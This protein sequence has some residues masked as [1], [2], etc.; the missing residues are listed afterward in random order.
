LGV[1]GMASAHGHYR[2]RFD[3][4]A[5][6]ASMGLQSTPRLFNNKTF[7]YF[8]VVIHLDDVFVPSIAM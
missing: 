4:S 1:R 6:S 3:A 7:S 5:V 2:D 8:M